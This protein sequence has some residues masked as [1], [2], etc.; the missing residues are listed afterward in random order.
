METVIKSKPSKKELEKIF[1]SVKAKKSGVDIS[2][3]V[4]KVKAKGNS[5]ML[6]RKLRDEWK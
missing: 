6:Q 4:G 2:K 1:A 3:Y 5:I